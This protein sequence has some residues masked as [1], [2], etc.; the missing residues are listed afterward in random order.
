MD[1]NQSSHGGG[2]GVEVTPMELSTS[3]AKGM[4]LY[5]HIYLW[6]EMEQGSLQL[7]FNRSENSVSVI[8]E[9]YTDNAC[10]AK[11]YFHAVISW[12]PLIK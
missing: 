8:H 11:H 10:D 6:M 4:R 9:Q 3:A 12:A 5:I 2:G 7:S 1:Y